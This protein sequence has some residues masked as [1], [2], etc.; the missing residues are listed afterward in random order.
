M[1]EGVKINVKQRDVVLDCLKGFAIF[2]VLWGHCIQYLSST[3][4]SQQPMYRIIYSFHMPLFM[5]L[6]GY[7]ASSLLNINSLIRIF[8]KKFRQLLL[9]AISFIALLCITDIYPT[10][11]FIHGIKHIVIDLWFLKS[12]FICTLLFYISAKNKKYRTIGIIL[13]LILSQFI[14]LWYYQINIMYPCFILGFLLHEYRK[15]IE[16]YS[17]KILIVS[18]I[19]MILLLI[20]WDARFW[21]MPSLSLKLSSPEFKEYWSKTLYRLFIGINGT[22]LFFTLFVSL[23]DKI[24]PEKIKISLQSLGMMTLGIYLIQALLV[25]RIMADVLNFDGVDPVVFNFILTPL[26]A[27]VALS[28][29]VALVKLM[30]QSTIC[31]RLFLGK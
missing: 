21:E 31:S 3:H 7:F 30:Q 27:L 11:G 22:V 2:L 29:C 20:P 12:A 24:I 28:M 18:G 25:E 13:S 10:N 6:V 26:L 14:I 23:A 17:T 4:Y 8:W 1:T 16:A 15:K 9:P 19:L 5:A